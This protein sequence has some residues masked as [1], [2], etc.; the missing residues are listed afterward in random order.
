MFNSIRE[1]I[2]EKGKNSVLDQIGCNV[3]MKKSIHDNDIMEHNQSNLRF[4]ALIQSQ[5]IKLLN[6][7]NNVLFISK[8]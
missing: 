7:I 1:K 2:G 3:L 5:K 6:S 8:E 4:Q